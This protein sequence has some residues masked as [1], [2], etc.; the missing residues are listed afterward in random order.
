MAE[1]WSTTKSMWYRK[2]HGC[3][4]ITLTWLLVWCRGLFVGWLLPMLKVN[5]LY[6]L[7][8]IRIITVYLESVIKVYLEIIIIIDLKRIIT[9]RVITTLYL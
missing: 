8:T 4:I 5:K 6:N 7:P 1:E 9:C 3:A 2:V